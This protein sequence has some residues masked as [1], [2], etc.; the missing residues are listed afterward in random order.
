MKIAYV[1]PHPELSGGNKVVVQHAHILRDLGHQ[2]TVLGEGPAPA[3]TRIEVPYLDY[4]SA[5]SPSV[6]VAL[7]EQDLVIATFW[8]TIGLVQRLGLGPAAHF[9]QGYEGDLAHLRPSLAEIEEAYRCPMPSLTVSPHLAEL[10]ARRFGR[11]SRVVPP[12]VDPAFRPAARI[13]PR[14]R[15]WVAVPGIFEAE[16]KDVRTALQA[17]EILRSKGV[18]ARVLRFATL[19]L[20]DEERRLLAP[21]RYLCAVPPGEVA[22]RL[23]RCDLLILPSRAAEGFGLP[24]LEAMASG[25]PVVGSR[26]PSL[27]SF[28]SG[29]AELVPPGD[30]GAFAA[31][32]HRLLT[33]P[34]AWRRA[35]RAGLRAVRPFHSERISAALDAAMGWARDHAL[36]PSALTLQSSAASI[37]PAP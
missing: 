33:T 13:S 29:A 20:T 6:A 27:E 2:V 37:R 3:W 1:L 22:R 16:V 10:L 23:R 28:A 21:E 35:R 15:P 24:A 30:A 18:P 9:C 17:V 14:R 7:P 32:A 5:A 8:T 11:A 4:G 34:T 31:A 25:V 19:P 26:I 12:P 36:S